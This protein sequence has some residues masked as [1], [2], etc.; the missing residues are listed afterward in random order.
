M[1]KATRAVP[2]GYHTVTPGICV[3]GAD[4]ALEFYQQAFG[5]QVLMRMPGPDGKVM[6]AEIKLGDSIMF[7]SDEFTQM[8]NS[9]RAP[10]SLNGATGTLYL[11]LPDADAAFARAVKAG[12][13]VL[14]PVADMF[15]G[16][17]CGQVQDPFG[18][19]WWLAT[20]TEDLTQ[21]E[22]TTRQQAFFASA[23]G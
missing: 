20:H 15:W 22:M 1:A 4:R 3:R 19:I 12:A 7:L 23:R 17:R 21:A 18:H 9:P 2:E 16:D 5:A 10:E 11:Y 14:A 13:K 8:P 6:H